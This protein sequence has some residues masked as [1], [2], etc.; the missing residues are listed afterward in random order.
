MFLYRWPLQPSDAVMMIQKLF[1]DYVW[2]GIVVNSYVFLFWTVTNQHFI[3]IWLIS[4]T[5]NAKTFRLLMRNNCLIFF[6]HMNCF[7]QFR[8]R[9]GLQLWLILVFTFLYNFCFGINR[10]MFVPKFSTFFYFNKKTKQW[11]FKENKQLMSR[12]K[13]VFKIILHFSCVKVIS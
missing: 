5:C 3:L 2:E 8:I 13:Q 1:F 4:Q 6:Q 9:I 11:F 10:R 7:M 12:T